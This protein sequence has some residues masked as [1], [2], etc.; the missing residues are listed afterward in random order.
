MEINSDSACKREQETQLVLFVM[1]F[2]KMFV[3][4]YPVP[5]LPTPYT[6]TILIPE[7]CDCVELYGEKKQNTNKQTK[8]S[9][10]V[11][12]RIKVAN[13]LALK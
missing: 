3:P 1:A 12:E 4:P 13:A 2:R 5:N 7:A 10:K 9:I 6:Y 8:V 11:K